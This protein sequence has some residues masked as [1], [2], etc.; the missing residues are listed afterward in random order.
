MF[1]C[2]TDTTK[3]DLA[4]WAT[5]GTFAILLA[6]IGFSLV[7]WWQAKH[8]IKGFDFLVPPREWKWI[9]RS[10]DNPSTKERHTDQLHIGIGR[11]E[12]FFVL[13]SRT[14]FL[15]RNEYPARFEGTERNKPVLLDPGITKISILKDDFYTHSFLIETYGRWQGRIMFEFYVETVGRVRKSLDISVDENNDEI[16][17]LKKVNNATP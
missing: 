11:Y 15:I 7:K 10:F 6:G 4:F 12:L 8:P 2:L 14:N 13:T 16:P 17:F 9:S 1:A 3:S 5:M